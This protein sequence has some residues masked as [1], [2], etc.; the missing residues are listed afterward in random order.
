MKGRR[1]NRKKVAETQ[2]TTSEL[3]RLE[4]N[5]QTAD[6]CREEPFDLTNLIGGTPE[7]S[8]NIEG[9]NVPCLLDTGAN[10]TTITERF[11]HASGLAGKCNLKTIRWLEVKAANGKD[12]PYLGYFEADVKVN[13]LRLPKCGILVTSDTSFTLNRKQRLPGVL[14]TNVLS[15]IPNAEQLFRGLNQAKPTTERK[16]Q[17]TIVKAAEAVC[18]PPNS[19]HDLRVR[20]G[21]HCGPGILEASNGQLPG[22]LVVMNTLIDTDVPIAYVRVANFGSKEV[23]VQP[24]ARV[25]VLR[26][27]DIIPGNE[28]VDLMVTSEEV[29]VNVRRE[30]DGES[31]SGNST[32]ESDGL[33]KRN[34]RLPKDAGDWLPEGIDLSELVCS[35]REWDLIRNLFQKHVGVFN[36]EGEVGLTDVI[37]HRINTVDDIPVK[38]PYRRVPPSQLPELK[39]HIEDLLRKGII[40]ESNSGYGQPIVLV[41]KK[42][43]QL[44]MTVDNRCLNLKTRQEYTLLPRYEECLDALAGSKLYS[45]LDLAAA[46][47]QIPLHEDDRHKS[48]FTTPF[49]LFEYNRMNFGLKSAPA[50][51]QKAMMNVF[52]KEILEILLVILDDILVHAKSIEEMITR[53]DIVFTR[54]EEH[55]FK[56]EPKKCHF[57]RREVVYWGNRISGDG[58]SVDPEKTR[59]MAE[60]PVPTNSKELRRALGVMGFNRRFIPGFS[61][62]AA[63][64]HALVKE[65]DQEANKGKP[66]E[67]QNRKSSKKPFGER[68]TSV[69]QKA[70]EELR[71]CLVSPP[72]LGFPNFDLPFIVETDASPTGG[73]GAVLLQQQG[74]NK[75]VIAY[76]S[77]GLKDSER[78]Y[79]I[80]K[81]EM[82][83]LVWAV[84]QKFRDYLIGASFVVYT[85]NNPLSYMLSTA[86]LGA[87]EQ[88]WA[89]DLASFDF[90]IKYKPGRNNIVADALSRRGH[91]PRYEELDKEEVS[92]LLGCTRMPH[93]LHSEL[94]QVEVRN[95]Q[96]AP[97]EPGNGVRSKLTGTDSFPSFV[98][99]DLVR[100]Q[101][102]DSTIGPF[103]KFFSTGVYPNRKQRTETS[104][105]VR[106]L[107]QQW[108]RIRMDGNGVLYRT[109]QDPEMGSLDQLLLPSCLKEQVLRA[110]HD[111]A[112]H[113]MSGRTEKLVRSRCYWPRMSS[114]IKEYI[115]E[116]ERCILSKLPHVRVRTP[117]AKLTATR[118]L[119]IVTTDFT[120]MD[121]AQDGTENCL[122]ITDVFSK[123]AVVEPTKDQKAKTVAKV[124]KSRF[125]HAFGVPLRL[126]SDQG[127][128][129]EG[130]VIKELC[131]LYG[132]D[133]TKTCAYHPEGNGQCE[134]FNCTM[135]NLCRVLEEEKKK[136]WP[137]YI[138]DQVFAY[139]STP[140]S[141]TGYSP[142]YL[143]FGRESRFPIDFLIGVPAA[144]SEED[145]EEEEWVTAQRKALQDAYRR[146]EDNLYREYKH[147]KKQ[148]DKKAREHRLEIGTLVYVRKR[149]IR[150][151]NKIQDAFLPDPWTIIDADRETHVYMIE[152]ADGSA[153][154][155]VVSRREITPCPKA[156]V[157]KFAERQADKTESEPPRRVLRTARRNRSQSS[158]SEYEFEIERVRRASPAE[159]PSPPSPA[160]DAESESSDTDE[161]VAP[162]RST[163]TTAGRHSNPHNLPRSACR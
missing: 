79:P 25:G 60:Y 102:L 36:R 11:F 59:A 83:A 42:N 124:L 49:G 57:F 90:S 86:K 143:M 65:M 146:A 129:F 7:L 147:R 38:Q 156:L 35:S 22:N 94:V 40:R 6:Q 145:A 48:A 135:H 15:R 5:E 88:R 116:C 157:L 37:K 113:Q 70:F 16:P 9:V 128:C 2:P 43:G 120:K 161:P 97:T 32:Q 155:K 4:I 69:H 13:D 66:I 17:V 24:Y 89:G 153:A 127:R 20:V 46:Y 44:R 78:N 106:K 154:T 160:S 50:T 80:M 85:D 26:S 112:G 98:A 12:I 107:C 53:L 108:D 72:I 84:T 100:L 33:G 19:Q 158:S 139:N 21:K 52:R 67:K 96:A 31:V 162:R 1:P 41:R 29:I 103:K 99:S 34:L 56:L 87:M 68:W 133:K 151:R 92:R 136:K 138:Q 47:N 63:P 109:V 82:L 81:L 104:K 45:H 121:P 137:L 10:V 110:L 163:R 77:R 130:E 61:Q 142:F 122:I 3:S 93:R 117:M 132:M 111:N 55:G 141:S 75:K 131:K 58:I 150:G 91:H 74:K 95:Q 114:D 62:K 18:I 73:L 115:G 159:V 105:G 27:C 23:K 140:H 123:F 126:H 39:E 152:K 8:V 71:E 28:D 54:L 64:L 118:P 51:F 125:I 101:E 134:R 30:R 76:A 119:Q 148:F 149:G 144:N 14:G